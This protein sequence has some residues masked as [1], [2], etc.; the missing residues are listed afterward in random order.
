MQEFRQKN[1]FLNEKPSFFAENLSIKLP[2]IIIIGSLR[3]MLGYDR[4]LTL[5]YLVSNS[6]TRKTQRSGTH[7]NAYPGVKIWP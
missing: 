5:G 7:L 1:I 2:K 3:S 4:T 6:R